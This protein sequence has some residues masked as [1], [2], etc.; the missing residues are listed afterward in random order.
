MLINIIVILQGSDRVDLPVS[1]VHKI[2]AKI[3]D[4]VNNDILTEH[5]NTACIL[6]YLSNSASK[7][8]CEVWAS[9]FPFL[10]TFK[11]TVPFSEAC[12]YGCRTSLWLRCCNTLHLACP[13]LQ[14]W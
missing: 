2:L 3:Q 6:A 5:G 10:H 1:E 8:C 14:P 9:K 4:I 12:F 13:C 7:Q 11:E